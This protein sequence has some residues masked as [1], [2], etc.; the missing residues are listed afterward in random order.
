MF[1]TWTTLIKDYVFPLDLKKSVFCY[2]ELEDIVVLKNFVFCLVDPCCS[3]SSFSVCSD[4]LSLL[5]VLRIHD[6]LVWIRIRIR[7]RGSMP[8]YIYIIFQR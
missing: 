2:H 6:I 3:F 8:R 7:I 4:F 5:P 1:L